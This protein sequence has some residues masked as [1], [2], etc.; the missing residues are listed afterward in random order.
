VVSDLR[1]IARSE[2]T[3]VVNEVDGWCW[4]IVPQDS[5]FRKHFSRWLRA[6]GNDEVE[7][8]GVRGL[9]NLT[10]SKKITSGSSL[11]CPYAAWG[12]IPAQYDWADPHLL[13]LTALANRRTHS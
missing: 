2:L 10:I 9:A 3:D 11:L 1:D 13:I 8:F 5:W 7:V 4:V 6:H 12:R